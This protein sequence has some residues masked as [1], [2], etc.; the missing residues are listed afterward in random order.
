MKQY[1]IEQKL[2]LAIRQWEQTQELRKQKLQLTE[3]AKKALILLIQN[4][5]EDPSPYWVEVDYDN[6]Q[7]FVISIIPNI[8]MDM[9]FS[10][11]QRLHKDTISSWEIWHQISWALDKWCPVS[12]DLLG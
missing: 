3:G 12:K 5:K 11:S 2:E 7:E 10:R 8:L 1:E 6:L 4:I 9:S